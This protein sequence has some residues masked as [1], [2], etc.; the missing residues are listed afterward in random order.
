MTNR[1]RIVS[2]LDGKLPDRIP[3]IPRLK[4]WYEA[5]RLCDTLPERYR[6]KSLREVEREVFGGTA[7]RDGFIYR[8]ELR[9]VEVRTHPCG[10]METLTEYVTPVGTVTTRLRGTERLRRQ[11]IQDA[12]VEFLLKRP[13]D[14][15]AVEYLIQQTH[16]LP[17]YAEYEQYDRA[18]GDEGYPIVDCGDCPFHYWMRTLVGYDQAYYHLS[19][20]PDKVEHLLGVMADCFRGRL[21][22][23]LIDSPARLLIHGHHLSSQMTPPPLFERYILPYYEEL[24]PL[25]HQR[26]KVLALHAD[27]DT[28]MIFSHIERAGFGMVECFATEPMVETTMAEARAAWDDRMIIFGGIPSVLL[29]DPYTDEQ[30]ERFVERLFSAIGPGKAFILGI[31]DNAMPDTK[32]ERI[33]RITRI[34][35]QRGTCPIR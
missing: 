5:N 21:W 12:Q 31:S 22:P 9:E 16:Y 7:G 8:S 1:E 30:L 19:D 10:E 18:V 17:T 2:I 4:I 33:E 26:D 27:N 25:L 35:Q 11:G 20:F 23:H 15:A 14:Y 6:G 32:I 29:E 34:V 24:S 28:R 13:E 3:W